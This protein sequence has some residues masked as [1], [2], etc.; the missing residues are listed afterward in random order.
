MEI[1]S[2]CKR[3]IRNILYVKNVTDVVIF[4]D[5]FELEF[6]KD[7]SFKNE[8][9]NKITS[10]IESQK[11][12]KIHLKTYGKILMPKKQP[13]NYR[14]CS[15]IDIYEELFFLTL[16]ILLA[17]HIER[18]KVKIRKQKVFSY[19]FI[20][21]KNSGLLFNA[22]YN[23]NTFLKETS[24]KKRLRGNNIVISCDI[25]NFYDRLNLHRLN[26]TLLSYPSLK[27][28]QDCIELINQLL[29]YWS[30][31]DSY[32]LP[33]GSN[34]S[35]I[36][37]EAELTNIDKYLEDH[38]IMFCRF[39]DDYRIFA[40]NTSEAYQIMSL[41][42]SRLQKEGLF[43]NA[44]KLQLAR[45]QKEN[46]SNKDNEKEAPLEDTH[47]E[48]RNTP[49]NTPLWRIINSY[50]GEIPLKFRQL[51]DR[52][53]EKY[54]GIDFSKLILK[55]KAENYAM[56][57]D[58]STLINTFVAQKKWTDTS[59]VL[60]T[61]INLQPQ[62]L[63][64]ITDAIRKNKEAIFENNGATKEQIF[65]MLKPLLEEEE[66]PEY[67]KIYIIRFLGMFPDL[68]STY[69]FNYYVSLRRDAGNYIGR[70][71]LDIIYTNRKYLTRNDCL[72]L[73]ELIKRADIFEKRA[74]LRILNEKLPRE[75]RNAFAKNINM[76]ESDIFLKALCKNKHAK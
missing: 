36:F 70:A 11:F 54:K 17:P 60:K 64:V 41:L 5:P 71:T 6:L 9:I 40:K 52:Q 46:I 75:E 67:I 73:K 38:K 8:I 61:I 28:Q 26:S 58:I 12:E 27:G 1:K 15:M 56:P 66:N 55:L 19:R 21:D 2:A 16:A 20:T 47:V 10:D 62:S 68:N 48:P 49:N 25:S 3:A 57:S 32:G 13:A 39:V 23:Y 50:S 22:R 30:N 14:F 24:R 4:E 33:V 76:N 51:S 63:P 45:T 37:A 29:L 65:D 31:R 35:R 69:I 74:I 18:E 43:F 34:A 53:I 42:T 59:Q 7:Q 44:S 72:T